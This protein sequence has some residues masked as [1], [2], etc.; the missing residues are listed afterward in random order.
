MKIIATNKRA[1]FDYEVSSNLDAGLV[2]TGSEVK[3][4][5]NNSCSIKESYI[6]EKKNELWL[7]NCFIKKYESSSAKENYPTR[8]RK[9]LVNKKE[10]NKILGSIKKD[11]FSIIPINMFFNDNGF[12]KIKIGIG[13]GKKKYDKRESKKLK[14]WNKNKQRLLKNN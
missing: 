6:S 1:N 11:G 7:C 4:L 5:R 13:K 2:L 12:V 8:Q 14:D 3:S 10:M 9:L